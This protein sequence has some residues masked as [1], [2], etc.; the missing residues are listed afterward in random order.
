MSTLDL[1][2]FGRTDG[3]VLAE[4]LQVDQAQARARARDP[5]AEL[6]TRIHRACIAKLGAAFLN[7]EG[8]DELQRRVQT[9]VSEELK[10]EETPLSPS[11]RKLLERQI[12]DDVL[13][14][15]P[16]EPLLRDPT[17]TEI[18]V[19]G[20]DQI[21]VER[22][23]P[24]RGDRRRVP[25]RGAPAAGSSTGSSRRSA[26][27]STSRRRWSTPGCPTAAAS[28]RSS[29]RSRSTGP[30]SR[31]GSSRS[32]AAHPRRSRRARAR[33]RRE[34]RTS[35]APASRGKLNILDLRRNRHRQDDAPERALVVHP[36][37]RAH[38]HDRG[39]GRAPAA[40]AARRP[41]RVAPAEHR[42]RGRGSDPRARQERPAHAARPDHRR[43]GPR[44]GDARHAPGDEHGPRGLADDHPRQLPAGR[45]SPARA[46]GAHR[47]RRAAAPRHPRA[48]RE[49]VRPRVQ[50]T[51]LVDGS[52]R[53]TTSRRSRDGVRRRDPAGPVPRGPGGTRLR[54]GN[55]QAARAD[56]ATANFLSKL[57]ANGV[58]LAPSAWLGHA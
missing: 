22:A 3:S 44:R 58:D 45:A 36:R 41:A 21:Y 9:V 34:P 42:G 19:N 37:E 8:S 12:G 49:R 20:Y 56:G 14:Y 32:D 16:L 18:M 13:G 17:V 47:R 35:S 43:R 48:D 53:V 33:S 26:G 2:G 25:R 7:L 54:A 5:H 40:A 52:R 30:R 23:R 24:A 15:G 55:A 50:I 46:A 1:N 4:R 57:L 29:R 11:E 6:K 51:R 28:T 38:R 31:S 10:G 39:R 27:A